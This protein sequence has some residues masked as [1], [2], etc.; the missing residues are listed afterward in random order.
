MNE[1]LQGAQKGDMY[2]FK[3]DSG[4]NTQTFEGID[5]SDASTRASMLGLFDIGKRERKKVNNYSED[6]LAGA[7]GGD[8]MRAD[9]NR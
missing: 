9:V 2:D 6:Y 5:Y 3:M 1:K 4:F 8:T 7:G